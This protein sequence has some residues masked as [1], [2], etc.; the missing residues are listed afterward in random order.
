MGS[1]ATPG[2]PEKRSVPKK[3]LGLLDA[4]SHDGSAH[5]LSELARRAGL[6]LSTA[7]RL[8]AELVRWGGLER[9]RSWPV[10]PR[11]RC[12]AEVP[13]AGWKRSTCRAPG[14][15]DAHRSSTARSS[16]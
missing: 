5:S 1:Q 3:L 15:Q 14:S 2:L 6:P 13:G 4:F 12:P 8:V 11:R 10:P 9:G 16:G 7:H